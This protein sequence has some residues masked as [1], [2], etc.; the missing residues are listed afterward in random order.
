MSNT[1]QGKVSLKK[2]VLHEVKVFWAYAAYLTMVFGSFTWYRR[3]I[4]AHVGIVYT[5]YGVALIEALIFG[6]VLMIGDALHLGRGLENKPL[7]F[8]TLL[9]AVVF[10]LFFALFDLIEHTIK[11]MFKG[12]G[13]IES[14]K[15]FFLAQPY[16]LL[17]GVLVI[18]TAFIPFFALREVAR[19]LGGEG[20]V[21]ALFFKSREGLDAPQRVDA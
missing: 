6:K 14:T 13:I 4:L 1:A 20:R 7:I 12:L 9:K 16:E 2:K 15:D 10:T 8:P 21:L 5:D 19:M 17:A 3:L 18:F 11:A